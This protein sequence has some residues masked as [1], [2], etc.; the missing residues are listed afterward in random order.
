M[1][2]TSAPKRRASDRLDGVVVTG[3]SGAGKSSALRALEDLG[4]FCVDNLP[5]QL[6]PSLIRLYRTW[7]RKLTRIAVGVDVRTGLPA[8]E[9]PRSLENLRK[10]GLHTRVLFMDTDN[11]T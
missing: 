2:N 3:L 9:L 10:E 1:T 8:R 7:G 4:Y 5:L 11:T 6:L